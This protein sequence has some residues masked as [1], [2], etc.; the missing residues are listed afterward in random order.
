MGSRGKVV[1]RGDPDGTNAWISAVRGNNNISFGGR[2]GRPVRAPPA[3]CS[4][5]WLMGE[6]VLT[7]PTACHPGARSRSPARHWPLPTK[8]RVRLRPRD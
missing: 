8:L 1:H 7:R 6:L 4:S 5:T 2:K 3:G